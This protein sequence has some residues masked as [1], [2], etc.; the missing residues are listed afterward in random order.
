MT[1]PRFGVIATPLLA[2][3]LVYARL[4][5]G[6]ALASVSP[7][8]SIRQTSTPI[9]LIHGAADDRTLPWHSEVLAKA[10]NKVELWRV[11]GAGHT[12]AYATAPKEF[13]KRVL[14]FFATN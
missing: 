13:R 3:S 11:A 4:R 5:Y 6:L 12:A 14:D 7:L 10:G 1:G 9:L 2:T 8:D